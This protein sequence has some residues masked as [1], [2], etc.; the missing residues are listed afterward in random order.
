MNPDLKILER[1]PR[2]PM[3]DARTQG[4]VLKLLIAYLAHF[5]PDA[6]SLLDGLTWESGRCIL[7]SWD[8]SRI[9]QTNGRCELGGVELPNGDAVWVR[10]TESLE[11]KKRLVDLAARTL[12]YPAHI[13][14]QLKQFFDRFD[15]IDLKAL[16][17]AFA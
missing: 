2:K 8:R 15:P 12:G 1:I 6:R 17:A 3:L 9:Q 5:T 7:V 13:R 10:L 16:L 14:N 4:D 11:D